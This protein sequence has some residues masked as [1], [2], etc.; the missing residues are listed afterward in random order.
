[1][2]ELGFVCIVALLSGA[3]VGI[4]TKLA[5]AR[6]VMDL[7]THRG[8]HEI[9][10]PRGGGLGAVAAV[11]AGFAAVAIGS[12]D[13]LILVVI[14]TSAVV[15]MVGWADDRHD[16]TVSARLLVH[17]L[18]GAIV[19]YVAM[20][21]QPPIAIAFVSAALWGLWTVASINFVN[22]MDGING[23]IAVQISVFAASLMLFGWQEGT[24]SWYSAA[25]AASCIGFL[26]WNFPRARVFLGDAGSGALGFLVPVLALFVTR[27]RGI[28]VFRAFL[29][30]AALYGDAIFTLVRRWSRGEKLTEAHRS[31][32]YQR[33]ANGGA[34]HTKVT[35]LYGTASAVGALIAHT[36]GTLPVRLFAA[37]Y[38]IAL[39][40]VAVHL[41]RQINAVSR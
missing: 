39:I 17:V 12:R 36:P 25:V 41:R 3:L 1:M 26:P 23:F 29:P 35:L 7:P 20:K 34:G 22:F 40:L 10:T 37:L 5:I 24:A 9:P 21:S 32:I 8:S 6:G 31:H 15:T 38:V 27:Q 33:L 11:L 4:V 28:E 13:T 18:S 16:L 19:G 14:G 30:L 2:S